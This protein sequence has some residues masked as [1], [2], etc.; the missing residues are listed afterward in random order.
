MNV[1]PFEMLMSSPEAEIRQRLERLI[2]K[3]AV[4][5]ATDNDRQQLQELQKRRVEIMQP[6]STKKRRALGAA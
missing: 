6:R 2:E 3:V 5:K 4:G 1:H